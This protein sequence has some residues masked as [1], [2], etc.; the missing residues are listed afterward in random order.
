MKR[1]IKKLGIAAMAMCLAIGG[2]VFAH[3]TDARADEEDYKI[4]FHYSRE[5]KDY[6]NYKIT[7]WAPSGAKQVGNFKSSGDEGTFSFTFTPDVEND[8]YV[9]FNIH[10]ASES[11]VYAN[12]EVDLSQIN[13]GKLDVYVVDQK[14]MS[15]NKPFVEE[16]ASEETTVAEE[17]T[18]VKEEVAATNTDTTSE[19]AAADTKTTTTGNAAQTRTHKSYKVNFG[20]AILLDIVLFAVIGA[21]CFLKL[22]KEKTPRYK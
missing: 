21:L 3:S 6:T 18:A 1:F 7:V 19:V 17:T 15:I 20:V 12:T 22:S 2:A 9:N 5:D 8:T 16:G 14:G 11:E 13:A 10:D 4:T